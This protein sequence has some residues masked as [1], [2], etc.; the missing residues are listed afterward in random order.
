MNEFPKREEVDRI[1]A[2]YPKGTRVELIEMD[3]PY[4]NDM[5]PGLKGTVMAVDDIATVHIAWDNGI[6]LGAVYGV[7]RI[8]RI[9]E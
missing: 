7:D 5:L 6:T 8:R 9:S 4:R 1:K 2:R 3:D